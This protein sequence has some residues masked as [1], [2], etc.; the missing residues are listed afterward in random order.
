[1]KILEKQ[2]HSAINARIGKKLDSSPNALAFSRFQ[3]SRKVEPAGNCQKRTNF[4]KK[5]R[6]SGR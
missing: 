4:Q 1:M 6:G 5:A 2:N 3:P